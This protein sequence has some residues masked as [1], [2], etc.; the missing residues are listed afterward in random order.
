MITIRALLLFILS[1]LIIYYFLY[2]YA[3]REI[4]H[5]IISMFG[6]LVVIYL[7]L[8]FE[9]YNSLRWLSLIGKY[10]LQIYLM[11]SIFLA[12]S[13]VILLY[14]FN[15]NYLYIHILSGTFCGLIFPLMIG[16][17]IKHYHLRYVFQI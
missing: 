8:F 17:Y 4:I 9:K 14:S 16:Y 1:Y 2:S 13:R 7:S 11:H 5:L 3:H 12:G 6:V 10:S 15:I